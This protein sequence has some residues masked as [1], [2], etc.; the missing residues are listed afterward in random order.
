MRYFE[1]ATL[2]VA[3]A[4]AVLMYISTYSLQLDHSL[5]GGHHE[6]IK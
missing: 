5:L 4:L 6:R 2:V 3:G 1:I